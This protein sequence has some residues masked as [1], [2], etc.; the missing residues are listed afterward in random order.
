M[1]AWSPRAEQTLREGGQTHSR[2]SSAHPQEDS[3][4]LWSEPLTPDGAETG[5]AAR[6][7]AAISPQRIGRW[8]GSV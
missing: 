2:C 6:A 5:C 1:R 3:I 7:E 4:Y 8:V